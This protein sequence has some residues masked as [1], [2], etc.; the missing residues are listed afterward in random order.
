MSSPYV[1]FGP[2]CLIRP[3]TAQSA[4]TE[5]PCGRFVFSMIRYSRTR[6]RD[7]TSCG[8][9][10]LTRTGGTSLPI[11]I[12]GTTAVDDTSIQ[13]CIFVK[14]L[15]RITESAEDHDSEADSFSRIH[16]SKW[17]TDF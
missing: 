16:F 9:R 8:G 17:A 15:R 14:S 7:G 12:S 1:P 4:V 10:R 11:Q 2:D 6:S 3:Q 5:W 13:C